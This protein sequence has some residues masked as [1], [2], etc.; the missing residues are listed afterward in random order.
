MRKKL[1]KMHFLSANMKQEKQLI[2]VAKSI[3]HLRSYN[4]TDIGNAESIAA[5]YRDKIVYS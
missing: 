3:K 1:K 4:M 5:I 2:A